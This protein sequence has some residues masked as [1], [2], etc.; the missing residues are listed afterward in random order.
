M[1][2]SLSLSAVLVAAALV[3]TACSS[4]SPAADSVPETS[5][6]AASSFPVSVPTMF[7]AVS[8]K[9]A[10]KRVVALG[11]AD[12]ETLYALGVQP[13]AV[14]DWLGFGG[15]GVGPWATSLVK[16]T[17][18]QVGTT[19]PDFEKIAALAP[20]LIL[21]VRSDNSRKTYTTLSKIAPTV[22]GP[23]GVGAYATS[24]RQQVRTI[25]KAVGLVAKGEQ[26]IADTQARFTK[27]AAANPSLKGKT[28]AV[29][30]LFGTNQWGAYV[31]G[32][33]RVDFLTSLGMTNAPAIEKQKASSFFINVSPEK[34]TLFNAGLTVMFAIGDNQ[35]ALTSNKV[36]AGLPSAK[37]GHLLILDKQDADAYSDGSVLAINYALD[38][39]APKIV[40]AA[41][42]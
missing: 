9:T 15:N 2:R 22:Y 17:P 25:A 19:T 39:V 4:S 27:L 30:A 21:D 42:K 40:A 3:A 1:R 23:S 11:W 24:W 14:S 37:A 18:T 16:S 8:V 13:V 31:S 5:S 36:I 12:A 29:G 28:F 38:E 34:L 20:D 6:A 33:L 41:T 32:D 26:L 10:P 35:A 7:G